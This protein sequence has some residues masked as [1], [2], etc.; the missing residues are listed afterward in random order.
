LCL[1]ALGRRP[2]AEELLLHSYRTLTTAT[3]WYH[4]TLKEHT[5]QDLVALYT[6]WGKEAEAA[7]YRALVKDLPDRTGSASLSP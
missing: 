4:R 5:L 1:A 2:E 6:S 7:K 3:N